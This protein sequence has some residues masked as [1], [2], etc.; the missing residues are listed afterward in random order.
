MAHK[1]QYKCARALI[2]EVIKNYPSEGA[3]LNAVREFLNDI[4]HNLSLIK[5]I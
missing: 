2:V 4:K 3:A 5:I 1:L